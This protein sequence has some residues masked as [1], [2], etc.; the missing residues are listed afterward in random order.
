M[1]VLRFKDLDQIQSNNECNDFKERS[2]HKMRFVFIL[3]WFWCSAG[4]SHDTPGGNNLNCR[5]THSLFIRSFQCHRGNISQ[6]RDESELQTLPFK[7]SIDFQPRWTLSF[8]PSSF[9][10]NTESLYDPV[11]WWGVGTGHRSVFFSL[12]HSCSCL[13]YSRCSDVPPGWRF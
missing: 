6:R 12:I 10:D 8:G 11:V 7:E 5:N 9:I 4:T 2:K 3:P 1:V 13:T